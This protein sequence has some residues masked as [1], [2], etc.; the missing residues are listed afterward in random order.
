MTKEVTV[1]LV[2]GM[3]VPVLRDFELPEYKTTQWFFCS[4]LIAYVYLCLG[5]ISEVDPT[6]IVPVNFL[7]H[8]DDALM[9]LLKPMIV[10]DPEAKKLKKDK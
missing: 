5:I 2:K 3:Q 8:G 6:N 4:E 7:G 1:D 9:D 10:L